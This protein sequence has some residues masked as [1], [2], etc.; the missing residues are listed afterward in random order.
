[1]NKDGL[2]MAACLVLELGEK[3]EAWNFAALTTAP[4]K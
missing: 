1:M 2:G 4:I 3:N